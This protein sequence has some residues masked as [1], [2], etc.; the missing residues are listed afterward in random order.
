[1]EP[2]ENV[3]LEMVETD[4][5]VDLLDALERLEKNPDFKKV[6]LDGYIINKTLGAAS[7]LADPTVKKT[8]ERP[9]LMEELVAVSNLQYYLK[10]IHMLGGGARDD[11][12]A[13][14][15]PQSNG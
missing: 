13:A 3:E 14:V 12:E 11:Y 10:M 1:M 2:T 8:G 6:I 15:G 5:L 4:G 9:D 7:R